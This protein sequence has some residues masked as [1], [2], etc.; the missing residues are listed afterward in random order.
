AAQAK[1]PGTF[2]QLVVRSDLP[3]AGVAAGLGRAVGE[4]VPSAI[5]DIRS[6]ASHVHDSLATDRLL[7]RLSELFGGVAAILAI[8]GVYGVSA[9]SVARRTHEI[10][11]RMAL[12]ADR[13]EVSSLILREAGGVLA[14]GLAAGLVLAAAGA[15]AAQAL[16][17]GLGP[18]DP[19]T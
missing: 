10:G 1:D 3:P 7:A 8:I 2:V 9:Y 14:V 5:L 15:R 6:L 13:R 19:L 17:Y 16:L 4:V 12:G 11:I 18:N